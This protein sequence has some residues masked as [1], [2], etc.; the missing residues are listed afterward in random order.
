MCENIAPIDFTKV[1]KGIWNV[2]DLVLLD[3][4]R[5]CSQNGDGCWGVCFWA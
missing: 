3:E 4:W 5:F 1:C 2:W